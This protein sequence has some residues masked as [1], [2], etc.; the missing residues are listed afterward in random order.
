M[1]AK[2]WHSSSA[3]AEVA[4]VFSA[5][6]VACW[7]SVQFAMRYFVRSFA[8]PIV[9]SLVNRSFAMTTARLL[10]IANSAIMTFVK[11]AA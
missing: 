11:N 5:R 8:A 7:K 4:L 2:T 10:T 9:V 3:K 1:L 6:I